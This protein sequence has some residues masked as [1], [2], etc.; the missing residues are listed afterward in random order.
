MYQP[1]RKTAFMTVHLYALCW[2][3]AP[4]IPYFFRHY[5]SFVDQFFIYDD[6]SSDASLAL[7]QAQPKTQVFSITII[8]STQEH[9]LSDTRF[10]FRY[11]YNEMWKHSRGRADYVILCNIDEFFYHPQMKDYL[12]KCYQTG[13]TVIPTRGFD[14]IS[15][16]HPHQPLPL[17]K[18]INKGVRNNTFDKTFV[19]NPNHIRESGFLDG[20]HTM[21]PKGTIVYPDAIRV[22]LLHYH[23][24]GFWYYLKRILAKSKRLPHIYTTVLQNILLF[25][26]KAVTAKKVI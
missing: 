18:L 25:F 22:R 9:Y 13:L 8:K 23:Y 14:M 26:Y 4:L 15:W 17:I 6:G 11:F 7:L 5:E 21:L 10:G 24:L 12:Q 19:F 20:R 2:N 1:T 16:R 3:E